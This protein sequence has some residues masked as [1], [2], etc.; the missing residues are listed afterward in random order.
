MADAHKVIQVLQN[1]IGD[2]H[3]QLAIALVELEET[4]EAFAQSQGLHEVPVDV[5]EVK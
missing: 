1:T 2:L 4:R 3:R 5:E